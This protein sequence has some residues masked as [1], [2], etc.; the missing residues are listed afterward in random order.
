M[1]GKE[2]SWRE[3]IKASSVGVAGGLISPWMTAKSVAGAMRRGGMRGGKT[4][5]TFQR[6][7]AV[8]LCSFLLKII[9]PDLQFF[10]AILSSMKTSA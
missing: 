5:S 9:T 3:F 7:G 1:K 2:F 10:T 8:W 4:L 6:W